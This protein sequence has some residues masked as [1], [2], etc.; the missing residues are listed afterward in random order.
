MSQIHLNELSKVYR[1]SIAEGYGMGEVDQKVGAVTSIP[2]DEQDAARKRILAKAQA[3]R[4]KL[5]KEGL[6]PVGKEDS[7]ID[8]DGDTDKSDKY[9]LKRRKTIGKAIAKKKGMKE[10]FSDWRTDLSEVMTDSLDEKPIKEKSV[11]NTIKINP[12]LGEAVEELGGELLEAE[13]IE[14]KGDPCWDS[15]KQVG[16][17]KKGNRMV[18]NCVPKNEEVEVEV[19]E[20]MRPGPRQKAM[21]AKQ[22]QPYKKG[23]GTYSSRDKATAHNVAVRNDGPGTPGYEKKSTGGKGARYAGYGDQGAGNKARRR[24]GEKPMRG[25]RDPRN[26]EFT[27]EDA[28]MSPQETALQKKKLM[29]DLAIAKRRKQDLAKQ[30]ETPTKAMGEEASDAMKDRRMERGGVGGNVDYSK[31]PGKPNTFGKKKPDPD[32]KSKAMKAVKDSIT[33]KYGKGAIFSPKK[34]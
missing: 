28:S 9:L 2:K 27:S 5:N 23:G 4:A 33:A 31:A 1:E 14:G 20:A 19:D 30:V 17:K 16:M 12:K 21:A 32:A 22:Y 3:K 34:K 26:E 29:V 15:H 24:M 10:S 11:K 18:P 25:D 6:D 13:V 7:D 8:N